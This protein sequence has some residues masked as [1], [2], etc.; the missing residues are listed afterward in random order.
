MDFIFKSKKSILKNEVKGT[1]GQILNKYNQ[2]LTKKISNNNYVTPK[3]KEKSV[4]LIQN[5]WRKILFF[6]KDFTHKL[7]KIQ[8]MW[9]A[10]WIRSNQYDILYYSLKTYS[11]IEK[12][13]KVSKRLGFDCL[14]E[15]FAEQFKKKIHVLKFVKLQREV[16]KYLQ[17]K[18][19]KITFKNDI[20]EFIKNLINK[21]TFINLKSYYEYRQSLIFKQ[22]KVS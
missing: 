1:S 17:K 11:F 9:R 12:I 14:M 6:Y 5:W 4:K 7:V 3:V 15:Q 16:K 20:Y 8:S 2:N 22:I 13:K 10:Y 21:K 19:G 18:R